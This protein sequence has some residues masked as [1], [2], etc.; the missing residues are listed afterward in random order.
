MLK[1]EFSEKEE[2]TKKAIAE[3]DEKIQKISKEFQERKGELDN[4][5]K[6]SFEK[7]AEIERYK[8]VIAIHEKE[9]SNTV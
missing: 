6:G 3:K 2:K 9:T 4:L 1:K 7:E 5:T 8:A